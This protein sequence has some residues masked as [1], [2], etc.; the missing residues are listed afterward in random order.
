MDG[1][2]R[3]TRRSG[4]T[5]AGDRGA[6]SP[7]EYSEGSPDDL[8]AAI[9]GHIAGMDV[10]GLRGLLAG[11]QRQAREAAAA[12]RSEADRLWYAITWN[13]SDAVKYQHRDGSQALRAARTLNT[14]LQEIALIERELSAKAGA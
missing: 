3:I 4:G 7:P 12:L 2:N 13:T 6:G 1:H 10:R 5:G 11:K 14:I 9:A 8:H